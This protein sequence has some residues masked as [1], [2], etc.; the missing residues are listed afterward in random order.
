MPYTFNMLLPHAS[1]AKG[2]RSYAVFDIG[3]SE[4]G[5]C[6]AVCSSQGVELLWSKRVS[7]AFVPDAQYDRY[8]KTMYATL[9]EAGMALISEGVRVAKECA[10][11]SIRDFQ[12]VCVL[13]P[14]WFLGEVAEAS[15]APE[16]AFD[17]TQALIDTQRARLFEQ[18]L[19]QPSCISWK[20]IMGAPELIEQQDIQIRFNG[21]PARTIDR[22][23]VQTVSVRTYMAVVGQSVS[24]HMRDIIHRVLPNHTLTFTT[25]TRLF[26]ESMQPALTPSLHGMFIEVG[27]HISSIVLF[28]QGCMA[29][30]RT[31]PEGYTTLLRSITPSATTTKEAY[32]AYTVLKAKYSEGTTPQAP[33]FAAVTEWGTHYLRTLIELTQGI[34]PPLTVWLSAPLM[35]E[36]YAAYLAQP[37][38]LPGIRTE[39]RFTVSAFPVDTVSTQ[40]VNLNTHIDTRLRCFADAIDKT[41]LRR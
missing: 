11:F 32:D 16:K 29:A 2:H 23:H 39:Q 19:T 5:V 4:I 30:M 27:G 33:F 7:Y 38:V 12:V 25:S 20:D 3:A 34:T 9:L 36:L 18:F 8:E 40:A 41:L 10:T 15:Y 14:P 31:I 6:I 28:R 17:V 37:H 13:A 35:F 22:R 24:E 26:A 1:I 21:Y